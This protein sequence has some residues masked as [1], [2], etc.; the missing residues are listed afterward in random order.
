VQGRL[1]RSVITDPL[2]RSSAQRRQYEASDNRLDLALP[3]AVPL[4]VAARALEAALQ[5]GE[6]APVKRAAD[7]LL[8]LLAAHYAVAPP[9]LSVLGARPHT[10]VEGQYSWELFGDYTPA[11]AK[12]RVWMR[13]AVLGKVTSFRGLLNTLLH[14]F[15]HHLDVRQLG[16]P[17]TPH[18]R[19][20]FTRIDRLYHLALD[21]PADRRRPLQ[22]IKQ[23][24]GW[25]VDW[26][27]LRG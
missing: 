6:R 2:P 16:F 3:D 8:A 23:G 1:A 13:T 9:G 18:T 7:R 26:R 5:S 27:K 15:C 10:V 19:G 20:F 17:D 24:R 21:T 11:T 22:W 25:R 12:I 14:E 4:Q